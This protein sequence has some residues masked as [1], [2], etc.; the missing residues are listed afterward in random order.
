[1]E[2]LAYTHTAIAHETAK[3]DG[4]DRIHSSFLL[5][6]VNQSEQEYSFFVSL[7]F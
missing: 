6:R 2:T 1:M 4:C 3:L 7:A 5:N